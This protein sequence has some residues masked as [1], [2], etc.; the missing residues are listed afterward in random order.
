MMIPSK[1]LNNF[2][3]RIDGTLSYTT[4]LSQS[5]PESNGNEKGTLHSQNTKI[6]ALP[7][8]AL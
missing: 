1:R 4:T 2:I 7:S 8:D 6:G 5:E 3:W